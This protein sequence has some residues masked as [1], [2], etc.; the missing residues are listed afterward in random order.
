MLQTSQSLMVFIFT[1]WWNGVFSTCARMLLA[2][3]Y[4]QYMN[5]LPNTTYVGLLCKSIRHP[6][7]VLSTA[8]GS[9]SPYLFLKTIQQH[10][11]TTSVVV[12][13]D[14]LS[15]AV[16]IQNVSY[17]SVKKPWNMHWN[18]WRFFFVCAYP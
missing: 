16:K 5:Q 15:R 14:S 4:P 6:H 10:M 11:P 2:S 3:R 8:V 13:V 18:L 7:L 9:A 1:S 17:M 12:L